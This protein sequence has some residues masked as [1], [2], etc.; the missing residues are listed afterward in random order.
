MVELGKGQAVW[1]CVLNLLYFGSYVT[2]DISMV[3]SHWP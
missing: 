3:S 2:M 1:L